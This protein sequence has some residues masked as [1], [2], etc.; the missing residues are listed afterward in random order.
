MAKKARKLAKKAA[1]ERSVRAVLRRR[2]GELESERLYL[3]QQ[4]AQ[5]QE[6]FAEARGQLK[7]T[8][9]AFDG[10]RG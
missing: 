9:R 5:W 3:E 10:E 4:L 1:E 6:R 8:L 7:A 2:I